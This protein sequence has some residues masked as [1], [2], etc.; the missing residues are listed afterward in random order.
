MQAYLGNYDS[1]ED[2]LCNYATLYWGLHCE[3][4]RSNH[5]STALLSEFLFGGEHLEDWLEN[6]RRTSDELDWNSNLARKLQVAASSPASPLFAI[7]CFGLVEVLQENKNAAK[8]LNWDCVNNDEASGIYLTARW[9]HSESVKYLIS[10]HSNVNALGGQ[11]GS[12]LQA[13]AF[14]G[15]EE[16]VLLLLKN[17]AIISSSGYFSD[18]IQTSI[19]GGHPLIAKTILSN[20]FQFSDQAHFDSCLSL[21]AISGYF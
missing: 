9:G 14:T 4:T 17:G 10:Q 11:F 12:A 3:N 1:S 16:I 8:I 2:K 7:C 15:H 18:P 20:D 13:S 5:R 21:A 6:T 19:A